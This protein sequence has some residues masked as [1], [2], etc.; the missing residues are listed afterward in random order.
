[1]GFSFFSNRSNESS[2]SGGLWFELSTIA[3]LEK[4]I[5][6]SMS[7]AQI[8]FKHSTRCIISSIALKNFEHEWNTDEHEAGLHLLDLIQFRE[9]SNRIAEQLDVV[10]QSPQIIVLE[11]GEV[12]LHRSHQSIDAGEVITRLKR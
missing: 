8:I 2:E 12:T 7:S 10:H 5:A 9:V 3:G 11:Q 4:I 6:D 1:M